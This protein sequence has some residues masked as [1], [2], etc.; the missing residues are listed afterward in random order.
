[1]KAYH[2]NSIALENPFLKL[3]TSILA[4]RISRYSEQQNLLPLW[5]FGFR[6]GRSTTSAAGL[7]Y[8]IINSRLSSK[9][10][11]FICFVDFSK[12]FDTIRRDLHETSDFWSR[13][14]QN[15]SASQ[16]KLN[17]C[18]GFSFWAAQVWNSIP[19]SI[20]NSCSSDSTFKKDLKMFVKQT[21]T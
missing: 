8:E 10:R 18:R 13:A 15:L 14:R 21:F 2:H 4:E 6:K 3:L 16:P 12:C 20:R 5:Q 1:M 9:K 17:C 7:L 11:T 19:M